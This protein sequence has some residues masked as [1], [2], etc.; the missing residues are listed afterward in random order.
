MYEIQKRFEIMRKSSFPLGTRYAIQIGGLLPNCR[1][2]FF[3]Q[4]GRWIISRIYF[5]FAS[6]LAIP[7]HLDNWIEYPIVGAFA[8]CA[9][10]S[11]SNV[12]HIIPVSCNGLMNV[13]IIGEKRILESQKNV[14]LL[15][16][17]VYEQIIKITEECGNKKWD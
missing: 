4:F 10:V 6:N 1:T 11:D 3:N 13:T 14:A 7:K 17:Q 2:P 5:I 9:G 8:T 15:T 16:D 12:I